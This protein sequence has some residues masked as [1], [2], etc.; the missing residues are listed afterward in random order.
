MKS[1]NAKIPFKETVST[2]LQVIC[3]KISKNCQLTENLCTRQS[4]QT[5]ALYVVEA[6]FTYAFYCAEI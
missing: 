3:P 2:D 6:A 1:P 4:E 5:L